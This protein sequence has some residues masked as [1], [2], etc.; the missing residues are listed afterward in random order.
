VSSPLSVFEMSVFKRPRNTS[1][2]WLLAS[3]PDSEYA[4]IEPS[5]EHI[6]LALNQVLAEP[7][8]QIAHAY[9]PIDAMISLML[10]SEDGASLQIATINREG[11][12]GVAGLLE[13]DSTPYKAVVQVPGNAMK[14]ELA[15]LKALFSRQREL[16][17]VLHRYVYVLITEVAQS[18]LCSRF[19]TLEQRLAR[20]L[21]TSS[22]RLKADTFSHTQEFL[23][24]MLGTDRGSVTVAA[25]KLK[26][27][28]VLEYS[29]G[30]ITIVSREKLEA[31]SCECYRIVRAVYERLSP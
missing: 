4:E 28:G 29:R 8:Q 13:A 3:L 19:H 24:Q 5:L 6:H 14:I 9:F 16:Q 30:K 20:L 26:R 10:T 25:G 31:L 1:Q 23:S 17:R 7:F 12:V 21:L 11:F 2:N 15:T 27:V 22:D 18:A